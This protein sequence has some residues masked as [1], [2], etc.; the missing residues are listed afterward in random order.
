MAGADDE[1]IMEIELDEYQMQV[2]DEK[3]KYAR[4]NMKV[5][6][7][8]AVIK[9]CIDNDF[10]S[11]KIDKELEKFKTDKKYEGY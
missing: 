9:I 5:L 7:S 2:V 11:A 3:T 4:Q 1:E 8:D 10:D 6:D